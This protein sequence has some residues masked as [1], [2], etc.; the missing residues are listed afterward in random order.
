LSK[1]VRFAGIYGIGRTLVK[2]FGRLRHLPFRRIYLSRSRLEVSVLGCGQ[3]AFST[4]CFFVSRYK[5]NAFL[6]AYD[7]D[8]E[9]SKSLVSYYG[10][11]YLA[12]S[13]RDLLRS[14][15][16]YLF[17]ASNHA[18]HTGYAIEAMQLKIKNI[19]VEKPLSTSYEQFVNL[20]AAVNYYNPRICVGYNR[21]YAG[22]ILD[23]KKV[24]MPETGVSEAFTLNHYISGHQIPN[25]HWYRN[26]S[27]GTRVCGNMGHWIDLSIHILA[28]RSIPKVFRISIV[29]SNLN[30]PDDNICVNL[31]TDEG[32]LIS[33]VLTA[34]SE[35]FEGINESINIQ[36]NNTIA[37]IDD[38]RR[39][40]V[41]K[42]GK[43]I[44]RRYY[45]KD[46]G[47]KLAVEQIF[48]EEEDV[49]DWDEVMLS[50]LM[51]L[52][53]SEMVVNTTVEYTFVVG[54]EFSRLHKDIEAISSNSF[55]L[56]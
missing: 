56:R 18:S 5:G 29:Y 8:V 44:K 39:M 24:M 12:E 38:F 2:S 25:D 17:I 45:P 42:G 47:H 1:V 19:H 3:F 30:E 34:R 22:A 32:D 53:I 48:K 16:R 36:Y 41:W 35:P 43:K 52:R 13:S 10:F 26:A 31:T 14:S 27:E 4:I 51:M 49:R 28:W 54:D 21:P 33:I 15:P 23:L 40:V 6:S 55:G 9:A 50:T 46:V 11:K 20:V 37:K 7:I